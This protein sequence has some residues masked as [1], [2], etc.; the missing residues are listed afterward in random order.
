[1]RLF[2]RRRRLQIACSLLRHRQNCK[3]RR[4]GRT[5]SRIHLGH[6]KAGSGDLQNGDRA[7]NIHGRFR[8]LSDSLAPAYTR[9]GFRILQRSL[10]RT[11]FPSSG[12]VHVL[13]I[14]RGV[15][16]GETERRG[17]ME[18]NHRTGHGILQNILEQSNNVL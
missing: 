3:D 17:R 8:D 10:Q 1:M 12:G 5:G 9:T 6:N 2:R 11:E 18:E 13:G 7:S 16:V 14:Y 4:E 15:R